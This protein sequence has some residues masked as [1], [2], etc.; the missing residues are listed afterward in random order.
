MMQPEGVVRYGDSFGTPIPEELLAACRWWLGHHT[1]G[2]IGL[3]D[4]PTGKQ[5]DGFSCGMLV[6]N[7]QEHYVDPSIPLAK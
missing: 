1:P 5:T 2:E 6:G 3:E 7:A 4:L